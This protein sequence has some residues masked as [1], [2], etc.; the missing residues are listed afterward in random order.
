MHHL[1]GIYA[2]IVQTSH[3]SGLVINVTFAV[4]KKGLKNSGSY[5]HSL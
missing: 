4:T 5:I 1:Y 2:V 3:Y